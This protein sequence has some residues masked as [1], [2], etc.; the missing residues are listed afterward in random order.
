MDMD[1]TKSAV[2]SEY[3]AAAVQMQATKGDPPTEKQIAFISKLVVERELDM[4]NPNE[5]TKAL[6][7]KMIDEL[8]KM[9]KIAKAGGPHKVPDPDEGFYFVDGEVYKVQVA[10]HGS[11]RKYAKVLLPSP[12]GSK[13]SWD[14][15]GRKPF[16]KLN[17]DTKLTLEKAKELG[18]LY[19]MCCIC[20]A[21]LTNESSIE[22]GIGPVC[23][24]KF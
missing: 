8:L 6:A 5:L 18:H 2:L 22:A 11:G 1:I 13:G 15:R 20:G 19:G 16:A 24:G 23:A 12:G 7:S 14:Y 17:E 4:P 3:E 9:P 10:V 21:T